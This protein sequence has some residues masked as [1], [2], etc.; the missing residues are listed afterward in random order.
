[1]NRIRL[2]TVVF[3]AA[4]CWL[5]PSAA[6]ADSLHPGLSDTF[7]DGTTQGWT[8]AVGP[9]GG[10]HPAPPANIADGGPAGAGDNYLQLTSVGG[11]GAGSR[12]AAIN[13]GQWTGDYIAAGVNAITMDVRNFG[14]AD[15]SLRLLIGGP[16]G[17]AGPENIAVSSDA[18]FLP[19]GQ[20][21]T[22]VTFLIG[23]G[24]LTALL[25]TVN[26]ALANA[27]E[28]RIYHSPAPIFPPPSAVAQIGVDNITAAAIPE[29]TTLLLVG[30]G[31]A[32]IGAKLKRKRRAK[33]E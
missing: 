22:P 30:T 20:D 19:A 32:G 7:E 1:M 3:L 10:V 14:T 8:V 6:R 27:Q 11:A 17:A 9:V 18:V 24:D 28:L 21:W 33:A 23:P 12:L 25:G 26:A 31:L 13:L 15:L 29:P 5:S 16:F 2:V 4:W